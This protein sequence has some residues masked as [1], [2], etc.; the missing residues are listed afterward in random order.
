M[1]VIHREKGKESVPG[2]EDAVLQITLSIAANLVSAKA[3]GH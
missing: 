1:E 2:A 3:Q